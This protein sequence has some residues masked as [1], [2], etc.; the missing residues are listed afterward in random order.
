MF[1]HMSKHM[2]LPYLFSTIKV[3]I[4]E[5]EPILNQFFARQVCFHRVDKWMIQLY[6]VFCLP[7]YKECKNQHGEFLFL[8]QHL[9]FSFTVPG[10]ILAYSLLSLLERYWNLWFTQNLCMGNHAQ[11]YIFRQTEAGMFLGPE[12]KQ[13]FWPGTHAVEMRGMV[14][15]LWPAWNPHAN[16]DGRKALPVSLLVV[17]QTVKLTIWFL[18]FLL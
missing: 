14:R 11:F 9:C 6:Y 17:K 2:T 12:L 1:V 7:D 13:F 4:L 10:V 3:H 5:P 15:Q 16:H 8:V 18:Y